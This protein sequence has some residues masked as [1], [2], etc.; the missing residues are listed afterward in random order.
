MAGMDGF[1]RDVDGM[2][3]GGRVGDNFGFWMLD[4]GL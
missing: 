1:G 2:D 4:V 3:R